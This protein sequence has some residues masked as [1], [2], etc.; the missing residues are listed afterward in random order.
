MVAVSTNGCVGRETAGNLTLLDAGLKPRRAV[1]PPHDPV[2]GLWLSPDGR[3][4]AG[5][6]SRTKEAYLWDFEIARDV[7]RGAGA[8]IRERILA[9][10]SNSRFAATGD[11]PGTLRLLELPTGRVL[12]YVSAHNTT[13]YAADFSP[14]GSRIVTAGHDGIARLWETSTGR[15]LAEFESHAPALWT[16]ALSPDGSR[17]AVGTSESTVVLF[18]VTSCQEVGTLRVGEILG[19]V[20]GMLRFARDGS[21]LLLAN[22]SLRR[23]TAEPP[24]P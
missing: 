9:I 1:F 15:R 14:D 10:S 20:E 11:T 13:C 4:L 3:F 19:P 22:E 5:Y 6:D 16:V 18:D 2:R 17:V 23:W 21:A 7:W 12:R 8:P 24:G